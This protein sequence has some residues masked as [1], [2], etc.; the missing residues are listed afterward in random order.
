LLLLHIDAFTSHAFRGNPAAVC[1]LAEERE[2]EWMQRVAAEMNLS[3][4]AFLLPREN[5][6]QLRWFTPTTE[7]DL[8]G[9][10]TL[11]SAH[12]LWE[13]ELWSHDEQIPF[14]TKSGLLT[15]QLD[16]DVI[17]LDF[18]A[19]RE[20]Q[21][22]PAEGLLEALGVS[23]PVHVGRNKFDYFVEVAS[24]DAV[25]GLQPDHA[26]LRKIAARGVIVTSRAASTTAADFVS[27]FF[28]PGSGVDEDPVTGS[29]HACLAP[30][31]ATRLGKQE[32]TGFQASPRGGYVRVRVQ[33][34][35]VRLGG[36]AV[37]ILR[38]M[39]VA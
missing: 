11:A 15:A 9:H 37:T 25:R 16:G 36:K 26:Q 8:C 32:M 23:E 2:E 31:W 19:T 39:L 13:E 14:H 24:E 28:A 6:F 7:V 4:T 34:D 30:Y 27:R 22:E 29:A 3:E 18:P 12:M 10:A 38:G 5:G 33:G 1:L 17:E 21:T 20:Q 35:R